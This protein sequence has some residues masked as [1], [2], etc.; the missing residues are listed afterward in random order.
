MYTH[1]ITSFKVHET[2]KNRTDKKDKSTIIFRYTNTLHSIINGS[3]R[4]KISETTLV[5]ND[6]INLFNRIDIHRTLDPKQQNARSFQ[7]HM[8]HFPR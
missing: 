1:L 6:P 8:K 7:V 5:L 4:Q 2:K 3:R